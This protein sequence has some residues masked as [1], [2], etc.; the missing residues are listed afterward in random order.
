MNGIKVHF[1][2]EDKFL[3]FQEFKT[4]KLPSKYYESI[5]ISYDEDCNLFGHC[6]SR[7]GI[8]WYNDDEPGIILNDIIVDRGFDL[9][10]KTYYYFR[11]LGEY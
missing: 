2:S 9:D 1:M 8:I 4:D 5:I 10:Y 7:N 6:I 3:L 11:N